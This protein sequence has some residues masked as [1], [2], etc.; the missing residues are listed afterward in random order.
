M[1]TDRGVKGFTDTLCNLFA[2]GFPADWREAIAEDA[3]RRIEANRKL[4]RTVKVKREDNKKP[5]KKKNNKS[6]KKQ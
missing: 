3:L 5:K 1:L 2:D 4:Y 6:S